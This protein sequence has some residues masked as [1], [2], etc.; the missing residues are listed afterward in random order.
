MLHNPGQAGGTASQVR[1][2]V[3]AG[4][5]DVGAAP[6]EASLGEI[7][8]SPPHISITSDKA[9]TLKDPEHFYKTSLCKV[10]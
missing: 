5:G 2:G 8:P 10:R 3:D 1:F 4:I 9:Q 6:R 7:L